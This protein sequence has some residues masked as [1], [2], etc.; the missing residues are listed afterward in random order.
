V[1]IPPNNHKS[2]S[3]Y[4]G[5]YVK[6]PKIGKHDWVVSFDLNS[7]YPN[8]IVQYNMSPETLAPKVHTNSVE[9]YM[10][11]APNE[12]VY[13]VAANGSTFKKDKQ[14]ILPNIIVNY[15]AERKSIK[16]Q[17]IEAER[18]QQKNPTAENERQIGQ[19]HNRQMTIKILLNSLYGAL[20]NKYFRYF[21]QNVAEAITLSGQLAIKWAE[22]TINT[23][24]NKILKTEGED[25]VLAIDTDSLYVNFGSFIDALKP[26]DPVKAL[27][28]ICADHFVPLFEKSYAD[29]FTHMNGYDNRMVMDREVIA[30][31]GI[32]QAKKRYILN[33]HNS[34]G[35]QYAV[36]KLKIMG[37][38]AVRSST[39]MV[40]RTKFKELYK[41]LVEGTE[42]ETQK[43]INNFRKEFNSLPAEDISFPRGVSELTKWKDKKTIYKKG[44]PIH[45]RAALMFNH[46]IE[47]N[48]LQKKHELIKNGEKIKFVYLALPN[49]I[50]ENVIA[51]ADYLPPELKLQDYIDYKKQFEK[52]FLDPLEPILE[53]IGWSSKEKNTLDD[54]FG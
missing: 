30:S 47:K 43:Y 1:V 21:D 40:V 5:G 51:Y 39:P 36:P 9:H 6:D 15:Y 42:Q 52:T 46:N 24:M 18:I 2:K 53:A 28:K 29:M 8:L 26:E 48:D 34:E 25:Y 38:E 31:S 14:G 12:N 54:I 45:V 13:A 44:T 27:D 3:A 20:G 37:I 16:N 50:K 32:W 17:M 33:V 23:E 22:R 19:L 10:N 4:P 49:P 7:L 35:V 41:I 11:T